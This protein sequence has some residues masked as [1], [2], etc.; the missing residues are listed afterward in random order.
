MHVSHQKIYSE[1]TTERGD[2][3]TINSIHDYLFKLARFDYDYD[4]RD[5]A[6][7]LRSIYPTLT[8]TADINISENIE[9]SKLDLLSIV[10]H[11]SSNSNDENKL[12]NLITH[13]SMEFDS[14]EKTLLN[15]SKKNFAISSL[16]SIL[17]TEFNGYTELPEWPT[18]KPNHKLRSDHLSSILPI[19]SHVTNKGTYIPGISPITNIN[20]NTKPKKSL[21]GNPNLVHTENVTNKNK[22]S[23]NLETSIQTKSAFEKNSSKNIKKSSTVSNLSS[24]SDEEL[25][26]FLN[27]NDNQYITKNHIGLTQASEIKKDIILYA[28]N[29]NSDSSDFSE[30]SIDTDS[31]GGLDVD[32]Y[33]INE[34][35]LN[36]QVNLSRPKTQNHL[37]SE[38][39]K[40]SDTQN[41]HD[42][43]PWAVS[44]NLNKDIDASSYLKDESKL[45][46]LNEINPKNSLESNNE[47]TDEQNLVERNIPLDTD[48]SNLDISSNKIWIANSVT[49]DP[50]VE[51][52]ISETKEF[53]QKDVNQDGSLIAS[54]QLAK[55][56]SFPGSLKKH[57]ESVSS[58]HNTENLQNSAIDNHHASNKNE[59]PMSVSIS[60]NSFDTSFTKL[61]NNKLNFDEIENHWK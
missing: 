20:N 54:Y 10:D 44:K 53:L 41:N 45:L 32:Y 50:N 56:G 8:D 48:S 23:R 26:N 24:S 49:N 17:G 9:K 11:Y 16:S 18:V 29:N 1:S 6:K 30:D 40:K 22:N 35:G 55:S 38:K 42:I 25:E 52:N 51:N 47:N 33:K 19:S 60:A 12:L 13:G 58:N 2:L 37:D 7:I 27:E 31:S 39:S 14:S 28:R 3:S 34:K 57:N 43:N 46:A 61:Q 21:N 36:K 15:Q 4:I 59:N 5:Y